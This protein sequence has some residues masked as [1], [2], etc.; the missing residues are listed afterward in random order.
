[1]RA[2]RSN[3]MKFRASTKIAVGF[4]AL[5]ALLYFGYGYLAGWMIDG[6]SFAPIKPS[7]V[8][9]IGVDTRAGYYVV[10][11]NQ[12]AQLIRGE[13][14]SF[15]APAERSTEGTDGEKKRV[16]IREMLR[17]LQGDEKAL[18]RFIM[19]LNDIK[20]SDLPPYPV[21]WRAESIRAALGGDTAL[22]LKL[23]HDLNVELD[24]RPAGFAR[25][26]ALEN[27]IV[28]DNP[29]SVKVRLD[30]RESAIVGRVQLPYRPRFAQD[31]HNRYKSKDATRSMIAGYYRE[32]AMSIASDPAK[33]ED[34]R[35]S[36]EGR[37]DPK[38]AA[39]FA[40]V[41]EAMLNSVNVVLNDTMIERASYRT[42]RGSDGRKRHSMA[43]GLTDEG[44]QRLWKFTR[45]RVGSQILLVWDGIAVAAPR[46][47][48]ELSQSEVTITQLGDETLVQDVCAAINALANTR[49]G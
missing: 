43:L 26:E 42:E 14:G 34:V 21:V 35:A 17:S 7:S 41:P 29:V 12:V 8:N 49:K 45:G 40:Q 10:V 15:D 4:V 16:P 24:G 13:Q 20:E 33:R 46:I 1:M 23:V 28:I 18:S 37:I 25:H 19:V 48:H 27:G 9:I 32:E 2:I 39:R 31:V 38:L 47:N 6:K 3:D 30:G 36:L 5:V 44:R 11:A 22:Q